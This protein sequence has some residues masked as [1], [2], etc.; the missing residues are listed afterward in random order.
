MSWTAIVSHHGHRVKP[1]ITRLPF[2]L[3]NGETSQWGGPLAY[4]GEGYIEGTTT[5]KGTP[6][7]PVAAPVRLYDE[8]GVF[9]RETRS[10]ATGVYRFDN[11]KVSVRY[12][13]IAQDESGQ[14]SPEAADRVSASL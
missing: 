10:S 14:Y 5:I 11:V 6:N 9:V 3:L 4:F 8:R 2:R 13:V 12:L 7:L 1:L